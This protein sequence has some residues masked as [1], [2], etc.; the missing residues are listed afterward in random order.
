MLSLFDALYQHFLYL[1]CPAF[2][3]LDGQPIGRIHAQGKT[4]ETYTVSISNL[5]LYPMTIRFIQTGHSTAVHPLA[6]NPM[7]SFDRPLGQL[8]V[9]P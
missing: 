1:T 5:H 4:M 6:G 3:L 7:V 8:C 9:L 2:V